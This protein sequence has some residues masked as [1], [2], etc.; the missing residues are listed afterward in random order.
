VSSQGGDEW[1]RMGADEDGLG[2][3]IPLGRILK[4]GD[5]LTVQVIFLIQ[6][7]LKFIYW[8][9]NSLKNLLIF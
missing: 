6:K 7:I 1:H 2:A 3:R 9:F 4:N 5:E 8:I